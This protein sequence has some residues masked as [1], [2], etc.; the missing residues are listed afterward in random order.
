MAELRH[1]GVAQLGEEGPQVGRQL[2]VVVGLTLEP[3]VEQGLC[4]MANWVIDGP[5]DRLIGVPPSSYGNARIRRHRSRKISSWRFRDFETASS[6]RVMLCAM[7]GNTSSGIVRTSGAMN[8]HER[9]TRPSSLH[10]C[11]ASRQRAAGHCPSRARSH[12]AK[13]Q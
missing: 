13:A 4:N 11:K 3:Q 7:S 9:S 6:H 5:E 2:I 8:R 10:A 12:S 1:A